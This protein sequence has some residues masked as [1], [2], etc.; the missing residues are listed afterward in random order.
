M[1]QD[2]AERE[3]KFQRYMEIQPQLERIHRQQ[4]WED[5]DVP[6]RPLP[7]PLPGPVPER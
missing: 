4:L 3:R 5:Q 7:E 1:L 2:R 6:L